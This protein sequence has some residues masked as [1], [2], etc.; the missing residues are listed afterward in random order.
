MC[1]D[2]VGLN[3]S[4]ILGLQFGRSNMCIYIYI[5]LCFLCITC[6][7]RTFM[8]FTCP[9]SIIQLSSCELS[10]PGHVAQEAA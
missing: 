7:S 1:A 9:E 3:F 2:F 4:S 5:S 8:G 6:Y 10:Q